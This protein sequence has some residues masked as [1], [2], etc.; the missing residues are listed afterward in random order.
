MQ[1]AEQIRQELF[2]QR[3][4]F[5]M[6]TVLSD[7]QGAK[8]A[9]LQQTLDAGYTLVV[10]FI[11][12]G[13]AELSLSRVARRVREGGHNVP[14]DKVRAR[15]ARTLDNAAKALAMAHLGLVIDNSDARNPYR[16]V[17]TWHNGQCTE[18]AD[19]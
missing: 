9:F 4:S 18:R 19:P 16:L 2:E 10:M 12:I 17:E 3:R 6:E 1:I 13:S 7:T 8:L 15:F 14:E 5:C 11:R